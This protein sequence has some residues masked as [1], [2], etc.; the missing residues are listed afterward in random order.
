MPHPPGAAA[1]AGAGGG[2]GQGQGGRVPVL[3]TTWVLRS[4]TAQVYG[5]GFWFRSLGFW[6]WLG[7]ARVSGWDCVHYATAAIPAKS[8]KEQLFRPHTS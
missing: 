8:K 5:L 3:G 7:P 2:E 6:V 4:H 1:G